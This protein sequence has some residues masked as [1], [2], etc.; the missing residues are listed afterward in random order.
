MYVCMYVCM[1]VGTDKTPVARRRVPSLTYPVTV[2]RSVAP[3]HGV[4]HG[5]IK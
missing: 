5:K 2:A 1:Y 4:R 3:F